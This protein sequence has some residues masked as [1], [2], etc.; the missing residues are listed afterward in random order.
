MSEIES[1]E[2]QGTLAPAGT[3]PAAVPRDRPTI[4]GGADCPTCGDGMGSTPP[5][6]YVYA[7]GRIEPRF[8]QLAIEKKFVQATGRAETKDLTD[9]QALH[10]VLA[11]RENRYLARQLCWVMTIEGLSTS[12]LASGDRS[13]RRRSATG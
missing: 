5:L 8:P 10:N 7:I 11:K 2:H 12:S 13:R 3:V 4:R 6:S 9:R 1:V